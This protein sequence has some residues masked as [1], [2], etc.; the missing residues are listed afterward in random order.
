[1]RWR[2]AWFAAAAAVP[3]L[4]DAGY[5][6]KMFH[7]LAGGYGA[8]HLVT[9]GFFGHPLL[10]GAAGLLVSP[11]RGLFVYSP[12]LLFLPL[13][14]RRTLADPATR[15]LTLCLTGGM[16][17]QLALY[18][19]SD[20]R[21]GTSFGYRFLSDLVPILIWMLA[22]V[23]ASLGRPARAAFLACCL[24]SLWVQAMGAFQYTGISDLAINDPNDVGMHRVWSLADA[25]IRVESRQPRAPFKLL[26]DALSPP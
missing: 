4:L 26:R 23:L 8:I 15:T 22:P 16:V 10:R 24:F 11:G 13:F 3:G 1:M 25:P 7:N 6:W 18:G 5:N 20:W 14:F 21:G 9:G 12:F 2:A 19:V 17:L